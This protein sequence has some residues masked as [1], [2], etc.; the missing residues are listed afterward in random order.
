[1]RTGE[2]IDVT[3]RSVAPD[4]A[5]VAKV[6]DREVLVPGGAPGDRLQVRIDALS[7]HRP[8]AFATVSDVQ[9][10]GAAFRKPPCHHA[11]PIRGRCGG[12]A[13]MHLRPESQ[14]AA[15]TARV[16]EALGELAAEL[17]A[18]LTVRQAPSAIA[19]RNR[20]NFTV[21]RSSAGRVRF[22]SKQPRSDELTRMDGCPVLADPLAAA[23]EHVATAA[24]ELNLPIFPDEDGLRHFSVRL[25][26]E[27]GVLVELVAANDAPAWL[28]V[29]ANRLVGAASIIGVTVSSNP[30]EGSAIRVERPRTVRGRGSVRVDHAG[31]RFELSSD[32][33]FQLNFAVAE[34]M[35]E[36]AIALARPLLEGRVGP[37]WDLYA[38]V[39][40]FGLPM[41]GRLGREV[42]AA[43]SAAGSVAEG[44]RVAERAGVRAVFAEIDLREPPDF[45]WPA[46]ALVV[47]DPPR[48]GLAVEVVDVLI[49]ARAPVLYASCD[50]ETLARDVRA[51][52]AAGWTLASVDAWDMLPQTPHVELL[53]ALTPP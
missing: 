51:L 8:L 12:C 17:V 1:M 53:A 43:E 40:A 28:D 31:M 45:D 44:R 4:G 16:R 13:I 18:E 15:K 9:A 42:Y 37:I 47:V 21:W 52:V 30:D 7:Q 5:G 39:G 36:R 26:S 29:L 34:Q 27:R 25:G 24:E 33:F 10:R 50:P 6:G 3:I 35:V 11:W 14:L 48:K 23:A 46:P 49:D 2:K 20:S 22:G 38:G 19:Y 32:T 41:A